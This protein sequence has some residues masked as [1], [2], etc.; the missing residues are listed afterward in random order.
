MIHHPSTHRAADANVGAA[1]G[2]LRRAA[3]VVVL[4]AGGAFNGAAAPGEAGLAHRHAA[5]A[6]G[7]SG[8][9]VELVTLLGS[10]RGSRWRGRRGGRVGAGLD[11]VRRLKG[12]EKEML[13]NVD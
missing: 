7:A 11:G 4:A 5:A 13:R 3:V 6:G 8:A 9:L 2:D 1:H 10:R 12:S